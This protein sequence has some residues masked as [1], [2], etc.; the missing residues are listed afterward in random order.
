[1]RGGFRKFVPVRSELSDGEVVERTRVYR[2]ASNE[3]CRVHGCVET[4]KAYAE[5]VDSVPRL[6]PRPT[7]DDGPEWGDAA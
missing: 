2:R 1:M 3:H 4:A 7:V 6:R 5:A